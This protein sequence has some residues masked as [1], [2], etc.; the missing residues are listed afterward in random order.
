MCVITINQSINQSVRRF[1]LVLVGFVYRK[2]H[3]PIQ[4]R[5]LIGLM[6]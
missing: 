3:F 5:E 1:F 6:K 4:Y 2:K